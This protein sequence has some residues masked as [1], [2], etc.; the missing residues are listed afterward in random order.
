MVL[1][2]EQI[3]S[4]TGSELD[5]M[6]ALAMGWVKTE[7]HSDYIVWHDPVKNTNMWDWYHPSTSGSQCM[8]IMQREK[9]GVWN[10]MG[11]CWVASID[12][13]G[14]S[15]STKATGETAMFAVCRAFVL[16][17]LEVIN[18]NEKMA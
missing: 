1:T 11:I 18:G 16:S 4:A 5:E 9:I 13:I 15:Q 14:G 6:T 2:K 12:P 17:K 3:M 7:K 10:D 8:E